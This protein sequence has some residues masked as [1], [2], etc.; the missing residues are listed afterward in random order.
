MSLLTLSLG[1]VNTEDLD[2]RNFDLL[3]LLGAEGQ[4]VKVSE[5][6]IQKF[7]EAET[8]LRSQ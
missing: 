6:I 8:V 3:L 5:S 4:I 7:K 1:S 2:F